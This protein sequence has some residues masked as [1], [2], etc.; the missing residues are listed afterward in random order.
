MKVEELVDSFERRAVTISLDDASLFTEVYGFVGRSGRVFLEAQL[1]KPRGSSSRTLLLFMHPSSSLS[2]LP[3]PR[4]LVEAG[5]HVLC[6]G[7]RYLR[8]DSA[9]IM[10]KVLLD[11]G[12]YVRYARETLGYRKIV[13]VGWSG[14]G[15]LSLYYQAQAEH[16]SVTAT[17]AGDPLELARADL[18]PADGL[19]VVAAH[20]S[21]AETLSEW[22]DPSVL[23]ELRPELR[24]PEL[25]LYAQDGPKPP[26]TAE[27]VARF[28]AAQR[29]RNQRIT[30]WCE[31]QLARMEPGEQERGFVVH[32]TMADPRWLDASLSANGRRPGWCYLGDPRTVNAGPVGLARYSSLRSWLSQW[33]Y[34]RS[35]ARTELNAPSISVPALVI[36]NGADDATPA[37]HP[38]RIFESLGSRDKTF[39]CVEGA[40]HYYQGQPALQ[41]QVVETCRDWLE[42]RALL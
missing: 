20:L 25:D 4:A 34:E 3:L 11:L 39:L 22:I 17:P 37:D 19:L 27:F 26:Y 10:E 42:Q 14:G 41:Q 33:S 40:T 16:P 30:S 21:R 5:L 29:A 18:L 23:D 36:E 12:A 31:Q 6:C 38:R 13:L 28:R 32:R 24:D 35:L 8:N 2:L 15:S 7:S 9:L 1:L